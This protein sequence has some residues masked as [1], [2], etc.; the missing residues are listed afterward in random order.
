MKCPACNSSK[1]TSVACQVYVCRACDAVFGNC[2]RGDLYQ[3]VIPIFDTNP[4]VPPEQTRYFDFTVLGSD[5]VSRV[6]G[7]MNRTTKRMVQ[8]G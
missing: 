6:H 2:Y 5:G 1:L 8:V 7:W 4:D 3:W